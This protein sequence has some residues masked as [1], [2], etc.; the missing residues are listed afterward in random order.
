MLGEDL[1]EAIGARDNLRVALK[2]VRQNP[3]SPGTDGLRVEELPLYL[4]EQ[5]RS[6]KELLLEGEYGPR[7]VKR[8]EIPKPGKATEKR[9]R[10]IPCGVDRFIE[11]AIVQGLQP[12]WDPPFSDPSY[13]FR[14]GRSAPQAIARAQS[15]L[16][17]GYGG[18]VAIDLA[19]F[20]DRVNPDRLLSKRALRIADKRVLKLTRAYLKAGILEEGL[21][22]VPTEG[23]P[24]G[25]PLSPLLSN[26]VL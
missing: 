25:G 9:K 22:R 17:A 14:P 24:P 20:F 1:R 7:P 21:V 13:G 23:A 19:Q 4:K 18:V 11:Q 6:I 16:E 2:R 10:S 3:G 8:V 15:Y 12:R 5:W 26:V